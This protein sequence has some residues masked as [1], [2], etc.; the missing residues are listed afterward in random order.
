MKCP[1]CTHQVNDNTPECPECGFH[2]KQLKAKIK[3]L[4]RKSGWCIDTAEILD[5]EYTN[6]LFEYLI[7]FNRLTQIDFYVLTLKS[8]EKMTPEEYTFYFLN[9]YQIGGKQH[10]GILLLLSLKEKRI[11]CEVGYSLEHIITDSE[12]HEILQKDVAPLLKE[13]KYGE[14]LYKGTNLLGDILINNR[15]GIKRFIRSIKRIFWREV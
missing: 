7:Q 2:Y 4:P 13:K 12:S 11:V 8:C 9:Y 1:A 10:R 15:S 6:D 14:A 3:T 5:E